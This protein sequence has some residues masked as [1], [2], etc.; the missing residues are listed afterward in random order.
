[1]AISNRSL[2]PVPL[3][4]IGNGVSQQLAMLQPLHPHNLFW[5]EM[6]VAPFVIGKEVILS[7]WKRIADLSSH[8]GNCLILRLLCRFGTCLRWKG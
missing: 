7:E 6:S 3:S 5:E 1:M 8:F 4:M 2:D